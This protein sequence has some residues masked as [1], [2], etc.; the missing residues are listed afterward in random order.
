MLWVAAA[1]GCTSM[2]KSAPTLTHLGGSGATARARQTPGVQGPWGEPVVSTAAVKPSAKPAAK[3]EE[4][5]SQ[6]DVVQAGWKVKK[7]AEGL[8][9]PP[10]GAVAAQGAL[11]GIPVGMAPAQVAGRTSIKFT[12]PSGMKVAWFAPGAPGS[13]NGFTPP[14]VEVPGR[15][16]FVQ[17]GVYRLKL[18]DIPNRAALELYPTLEVKPTNYRTC[19][20]LAHSAV[21]VSFRHNP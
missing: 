13:N 17:G 14:Q 20:F 8:P 11:P 5:S 4:K 3:P 16:N 21:P 15:Y 7:G 19:T 9:A 1:T 10:P 2:D 18:S 12:G 6:A